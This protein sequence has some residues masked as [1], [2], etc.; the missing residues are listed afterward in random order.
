MTIPFDAIYITVP[1]DGGDAHGVVGAAAYS[2][3]L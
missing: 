1:A 2:S 3:W